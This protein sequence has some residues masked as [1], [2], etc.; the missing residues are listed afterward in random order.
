MSQL[1]ELIEEAINKASAENGSNTPDFILAQYLAGCLKAFDKAVL[2]RDNWHGFKAKHPFAVSLDKAA[3]KVDKW[4]AR[5]RCAFELKTGLK[6]GEPVFKST[7][8]MMKKHGLK[9]KKED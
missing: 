7:K 8:A 4:P 1:H 3:K 2:S 5:K 6:L 9:Y